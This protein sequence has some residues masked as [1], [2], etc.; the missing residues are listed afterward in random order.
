MKVEVIQMG[1]LWRIV[2]E[3]N[4]RVVVSRNGKPLDGGGHDSREKAIRQAGHINA[5]SEKQK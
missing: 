1:G 3:E 5:S 2:D 4:G